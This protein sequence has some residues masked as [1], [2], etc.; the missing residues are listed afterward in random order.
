MLGD[1]VADWLDQL[2]LCKLTACMTL[3]LEFRRRS[4]GKW[5]DGLMYTSYKTG[6]QK[7]S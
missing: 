7:L 6:K 5:M 1:T 4:D 2:P 3:C